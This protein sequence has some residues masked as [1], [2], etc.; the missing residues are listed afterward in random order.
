MIGIIK[1]KTPDS[2]KLKNHGERKQCVKAEHLPEIYCAIITQTSVGFTPESIPWI[3][4]GCYS[5]KS[6]S[7]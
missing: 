1:V 3:K 5:I 6:G 2:S 7:I 4:E